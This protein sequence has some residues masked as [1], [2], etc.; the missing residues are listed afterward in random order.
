VKINYISSNYDLL[1]F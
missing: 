1:I